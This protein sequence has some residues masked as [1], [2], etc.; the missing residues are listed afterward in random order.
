MGAISWHL[1]VSSLAGFWQT[2]AAPPIVGLVQEVFI[3]NHGAGRNG[4]EIDRVS[5]LTSGRW[6]QFMYAI[7]GCPTLNFRLSLAVG[8]LTTPLHSLS[9]SALHT[10]VHSSRDRM[11]NISIGALSMDSVPA[12]S[13]YRNLLVNQGD[14]SISKTHELAQKALRF[15]YVV[16]IFICK[17]NT[18]VWRTF[19]DMDPNATSH[20][21]GQ[22][23][24]GIH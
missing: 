7:D 17:Q 13:V 1:G 9:P 16:Q 18:C 21:L 4:G 3:S 20:M 24:N 10:D 8:L 2:L 6:N 19:S 22:S 15:K 23:L 5:T 11:R 14:F 12:G